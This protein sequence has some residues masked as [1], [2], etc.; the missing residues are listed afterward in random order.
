MCQSLQCFAWRYRPSIGM[1][2]VASH[3]LQPC[4]LDPE[5][6]Y[7]TPSSKILRAL[8]KGVTARSSYT[9]GGGY[10]IRVPDLGF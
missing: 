6:S 10:A 1:R 9:E 3:F 7:K 4:R 2:T 5:S 8:R